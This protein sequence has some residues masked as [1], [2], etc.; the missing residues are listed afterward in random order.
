MRAHA[1]ITIADALFLFEAAERFFHRAFDLLVFIT[2]RRLRYLGVFIGIPFDERR[3]L[4]DDVE[5]AVPKF[6]MR[7]RLGIAGA[8][9]S[10]ARCHRYR[11]RICGVTEQV[12]CA[13]GVLSIG[14]VRPVFHSIDARIADFDIRMRAGDDGGG[15]MHG[16]RQNIAPDQVVFQ[17]V[18][19]DILAFP[20]CLFMKTEEALINAVQQCACAAGEIGDFR[21]RSKLPCGAVCPRAYRRLWEN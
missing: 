4:D 3:I 14:P 18:L 16:V 21:E 19:M 8:A 15:E 10:A 5:F 17:H 13:D 1:G 12:E 11:E 20:A 6:L 7:L 9:D 2:E